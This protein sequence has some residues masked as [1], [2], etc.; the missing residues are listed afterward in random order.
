V[1]DLPD[2]DFR[3]IHILAAA[4]SDTPVD[5]EIVAQYKGST[6][7]AHVSIAPWTAKPTG[8]ATVGF[9]APYRLVKSAPDNS[10]P[11]I[12]GD[13]TIVTVPG[14]KLTGL[15]LPNNPKIKILAITLEK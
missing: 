7:S 8:D 10:K 11:C 6:A 13:Y 1:I 14:K 4:A 12:L 3:S 9:R 5:T 15:A 2:G